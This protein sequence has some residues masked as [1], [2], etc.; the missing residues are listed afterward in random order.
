[1]RTLRAGRFLLFFFAFLIFGFINAKL[2]TCFHAGM[3]R[4]CKLKV[5]IG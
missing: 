5:R 4:E 3:F 1:M 2:H